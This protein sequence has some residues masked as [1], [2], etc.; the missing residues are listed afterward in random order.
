MDNFGTHAMGAFYEA[1]PPE[2][3]KRLIDR[4]ELI[5]TPKHGSWLNMAEIELHVSKVSVKRTWL[6][7]FIGLRGRCC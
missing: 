2:E 1:F 5:F 7:E 4:F 6:Q 3:A